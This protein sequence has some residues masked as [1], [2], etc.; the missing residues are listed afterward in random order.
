MGSEMCIRDRPYIDNVV[1][2]SKTEDINSRPVATAIS[3]SIQTFSDL[4]R[5]SS[6]RLPV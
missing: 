2:V 5:T 6:S 1:M 4:R 3:T